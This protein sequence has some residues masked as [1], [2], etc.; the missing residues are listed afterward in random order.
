MQNPKTLQTF[1]MAL[2]LAG[3]QSVQTQDAGASP[4]PCADQACVEL[5]ETAFIYHPSYSLDRD[6]DGLR[7]DLEVR[8]AEAFMPYLIFDSAEAATRDDEPLAIYQ[9]R[10]KG[11]LGEGC[12]KNSV[13]TIR[14]VM[15]WRWDGGYGPSSDCSDTHTGDIVVFTTTATSSDGK[16]WHR[17]AV[18]DPRFPWPNLRLNTTPCLS[19]KNTQHCYR[20]GFRERTHAILYISAHKHHAYPNKAWDHEDSA[21]SDWGCNDDV[22][23]NGSARWPRMFDAITGPMNRGE[24]EAHEAPWF[25]NDLTRAGFSGEHAWYWDPEDEDNEASPFINIEGWAM[26]HPF[27]MG[28]GFRQRYLARCSIL[29]Y[30]KDT[31]GKPIPGATLYYRNVHP[32]CVLFGG[33][34]GPW[35]TIS[36]DPT[37][38]FKIHVPEALYLLRPVASGYRFGNVPRSADTTIPSGESHCPPVAP[39]F[40]G[41]KVPVSPIVDV[42]TNNQGRAVTSASGSPADTFQASTGAEERII[43][44]FPHEQLAAAVLA[45]HH[46]DRMAVADPDDPRMTALVGLPDQ[47]RVE[48]ELQALRKLDPGEACIP[49]TSAA[50]VAAA[51]RKDPSIERPRPAMCGPVE[52]AKLRARLVAE[53]GYLRPTSTAWIQEVTRP[54]GK[55]IFQIHAGVLPGRALL[56]VEVI[57][58]PANPFATYRRRSRPIEIQPAIHGGDDRTGPMLSLEVPTL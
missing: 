58:N 47:I 4:N 28:P 13:V 45:I 44:P 8:L 6:R 7:D 54:D 36:V 46:Q 24:P 39:F 55:A 14:Y 26:R 34:R 32:L 57:E 30:L 12:S 41:E 43:L 37:G 31:D 56:E 23:G 51:R 3:A 17:G 38:F 27:E 2:I 21:Y 50:D 29:G 33:C 20:Y 52:G 15:I 10:P 19:G 25:A 48:A 35:S 18:E 53:P 9:V 11:C 49:A 1:L 5:G 16:R 40:Y 22:D 42:V